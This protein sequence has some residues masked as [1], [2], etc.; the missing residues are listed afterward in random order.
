MFLAG[1]LF[2]AYALP[3]VLR[4]ISYVFPATYFIP[5]SRGILVKGIGLQDLWV[6]ALALLVSLGVILLVATRLFRQRLD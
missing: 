4:A 6:Q 5:V 3:S 1:V 2:P